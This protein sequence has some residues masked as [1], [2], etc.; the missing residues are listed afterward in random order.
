MPQSTHLAIS[1]TLVGALVTQTRE[2][3]TARLVATREMAAD[4]RGL[5]HG[6]F[7][8]GLADFAAMCAVNHPN[9]VLGS[10]ATKFLAPVRVGE[11]ML[12]RATLAQEGGRK[13]L[14]DVTVRVGE[15]LVFS[16]EFTCFVLDEHVLDA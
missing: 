2:A 16:G 5:V 4:E 12:A 1:P 3:A 13:R 14:V 9:V 15:R 7:T 8:F 11:E 10:A 6:G